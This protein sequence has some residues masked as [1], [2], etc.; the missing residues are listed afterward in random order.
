MMTGV[1]QFQETTIE[2]ITN[3]GIF[4]VVFFCVILDLVE[5]F[6]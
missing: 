1:A 6:W 2:L 3:L 5:M 4:F